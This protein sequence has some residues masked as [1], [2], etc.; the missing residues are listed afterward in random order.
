[1][2]IRIGYVKDLKDKQPSLVQLLENIQLNAD[3]INAFSY[4]LM[5]NGRDPAEV[6]QEW[7]E[8]NSDLIKS[9]VGN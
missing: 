2:T 6:A 1:M 8:A 4:E 5:V 7:V 9:W 3:D